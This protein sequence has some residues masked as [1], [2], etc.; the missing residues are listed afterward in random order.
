MNLDLFFR[1]FY[2][3]PIEKVWDAIS[4][5][6]ALAEWLMAN[7]FEPVVGCR[8]VFRGEP[9]PQWRGWMECQVLAIEP[10]MRMVWSWK[11]TDYEE[12]GQVEIRLK[13]VAGGTEL[14][15]THIGETDPERHARYRS[16]WPGKLMALHEQ[17]STN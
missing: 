2:P 1:E 9:T 3:H 15:L 12:A 10:P 14:T 8:F 17:L 5:S 4:T 11:A 16:G 7:D 6:V 13:A